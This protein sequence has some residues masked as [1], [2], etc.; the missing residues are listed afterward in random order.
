MKKEKMVNRV[1]ACF[2]LISESFYMRIPHIKLKIFLYNKNNNPEF[3]LKRKLSSHDKNAL[4]FDPEA[5]FVTLR[6]SLQY[7]KTTSRKKIRPL[8]NKL[9]GVCQINKIISFSYIS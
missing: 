9:R 3:F 1:N 5:K 2:T 4:I 7:L 6:L 8:K